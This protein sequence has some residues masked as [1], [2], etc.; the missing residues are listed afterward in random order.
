VRT[1]KTAELSTALRFRRYD[2]FVTGR[3]I[4]CEG[5][6]WSL[7]KFV[8]S[9]EAK[10]SGE[11]CGLVSPHAGVLAL[12]YGNAN[13]IYMPPDGFLLDCPPPAAMTTYC[14]PFTI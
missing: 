1:N 7:N 9:T 6:S 4:V 3:S 2:K 10:R 13:A 8:I 5:L 14:F 11:F 12:G